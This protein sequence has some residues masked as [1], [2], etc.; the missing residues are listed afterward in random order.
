M[1]KIGNFLRRHWVATFVIT[2]LGGTVGGYFIA[3]NTPTASQHTAI[4]I[5]ASTPMSTTDAP[6]MLYV[7]SIK[8]GIITGA[9]GFTY[10]IPKPSVELNGVEV[11]TNEVYKALRHGDVYNAYVVTHP[12]DKTRPAKILGLAT[13]DK[14]VAK[15]AAASAACTPTA[16][17]S[18]R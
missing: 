5:T 18:R 16:P 6:R 1:A 17:P 10:V 3:V 4:P 11:G 14:T 7:C 8:D 2:L 9:D 13:T 12:V 15:S